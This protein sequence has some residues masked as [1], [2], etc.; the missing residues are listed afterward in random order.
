MSIFSFSSHLTGWLILQ[1]LAVTSRSS[2]KFHGI[3]RLAQLLLFCSL[4]EAYWVQTSPWFIIFIARRYCRVLGMLQQLW[5]P[6]CLP[7]FLADTLPVSSLNFYLWLAWFI[8]CHFKWSTGHRPLVVYSSLSGRRLSF[9]QL[10]LN[11]DV[12]ISESRSIFQV[13]FDRH[14]LWPC[15]VCCSACLAMMLTFNRSVRLSQCRGKVIGLALPRCI[16]IIL[17]VASSHC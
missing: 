15:G 6:V 4:H 9:L 1:Q 8:P 11:P 5:L 17:M 3:V 2:H 10:Y 7:V 16:I 14:V 13:F 12:H